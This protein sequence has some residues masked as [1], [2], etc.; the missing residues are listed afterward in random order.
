MGQGACRCRC[1]ESGQLL[2]DKWRSLAKTISIWVEW[3]HQSGCAP[4]EASVT[5]RWHTTPR[6]API[7]CV[8]V[9][10]ALWWRFCHF[11]SLCHYPIV[12]ELCGVVANCDHNSEWFLYVHQH[13]VN[14]SGSH[15]QGSVSTQHFVHHIH[16]CYSHKIHYLTIRYALFNYLYIYIRSVWPQTVVEH[17][18]RF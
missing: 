11:F 6:P 14:R 4:S 16:L 12:N 5:P 15:T 2:F 18:R 9:P 8:V 1:S 7:Q 3:L 17:N 13:N 10:I